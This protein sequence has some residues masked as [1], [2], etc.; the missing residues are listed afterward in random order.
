MPRRLT[1]IMTSLF[2]GAVAVWAAEP[3]P[4]AQSAKLS[5]ADEKIVAVM[6]ILELMD[7][8]DE[9]EMYKDINYLIEDDPD[10]IQT[11]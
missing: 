3:L 10:E 1:I 2:M 5:A 11:D 4:P 9:M 6:E 8:T 7:L